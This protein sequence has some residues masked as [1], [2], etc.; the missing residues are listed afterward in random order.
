[1]SW[2]EALWWL[3]TAAV[4][5]TAALGVLAAARQPW[6]PARKYWLLALVIA[7]ALAIGASAWQ[8][9]ASR[10]ALGDEAARLHALRL[11]LDEIGGLLPG[12]P[13]G[14][15]GETFDTVTSAIRALNARIEE[16]ETQIQ[17]LREKTRS[18]TI[19]Q[20]T[21]A[22]M[23][24]Y[25][26]QFGGRRVVVSCVPDDIEAFTYANQLANVLREAG[27]DALGPEKTTI[28][29][30]APAMGVR[31][32][33]RGGVLAPEAARFLIDA[34]TRFNIP[35]QSGIAPSDAIP[36]PATTELFVSHKP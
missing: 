1:M 10:Q 27:W 9:N 24:D 26:R 28:F 15:P 2:S 34:F 30:E 5:V 29:G 31:L 4:A 7:G 23:A 8:Q 35:Y 3:P 20:T 13:G 16:L 17:V 6:R 18:R 32:F 12:G 11:R 33:V 19:D 36:D 14:T 21:A 22:K 25:L